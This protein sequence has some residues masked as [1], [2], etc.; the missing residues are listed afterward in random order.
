[1]NLTGTYKVTSSGSVI[2]EYQNMITT[3][4]LLTINQYLA[5]LVPSWAGSIGIGTIYTNSTAP[6]TEFLDHEIRRYPV[7]L[8]S[9]RTVSASINQIALKISVDPEST[10]QAYEL[11]V[12]PST[13]NQG[14]FTD[15]YQI[16]DFSEQLSG[17]S[18]WYINGN[19]ASNFGSSRVGASTVIIPAGTTAST[20]M[21]MNTN[22][23][24]ETDILK[25][26]FYS[27]TTIT[28]GSFVVNFADDSLIT[29][30]WTAS[31]TFSNTTAG[32]YYSSSL[33]F[34]PKPSL[35]SDYVISA[36]INYLGT[37]SVR[38]DHLKWVT[39]ET[40]S[41]DFKLVSRTAQ[42]TPLFIKTYGQ[43]MEIEYYIQVT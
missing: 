28:S 36:S 2:G 33:G 23:Y 11:G 5:G 38:L 8:K 19:P 35:F 1:M 4:G 12:F 43:P 41:T 32:N 30:F 18:A 9:Y 17:S 22:T 6:S 27:S 42:A 26:L 29:N 20:S 31:G 25:V 10:F 15:H 39:G 14:S 16:S 13:I 7:T 24:S 34:L 21:N 37:G 40:K 3:N